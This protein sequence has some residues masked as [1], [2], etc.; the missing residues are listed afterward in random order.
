MFSHKMITTLGITAGVTLAAVFAWMGVQQSPATFA[1]GT[2]MVSGNTAA[3][4]NQPGWMFNRDGSTT[5][6]YVFNT[7]EQSIGVGSLYVQ[8]IASTA[9]NKFIAENFLKT[10]I[11]QV[12]SIAYD[13]LIGNGGDT[14]D[15]NQFYMNVYANIDD[16]NNYYDCRFDYVPTTGSNI[17]FTTVSFAASDVP[18]SVTKRGTRISAC[19]TTLAGMPAGSY[20]RAFALNVGDTSASDAGLDGY[21][22]NVVVNLVGDTTTYD[23]EPVLTPVSKDACKGNG[24]MTFNTP[25]FKNQ[26]ACV[27]FVQTN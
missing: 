6:P 11:S 19:P 15:A 3:G 14:T 20:V 16:S 21:L 5:S 17:S 13:F 25:K 10:P 4:E 9:S 8:P 23:F 24:W 27:S 22:D 7:N 1:S 2:V 12:S 18:T 26:G